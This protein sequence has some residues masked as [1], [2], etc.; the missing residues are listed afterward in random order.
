MSGCSPTYYILGT[1]L[2]AW[3]L[4]SLSTKTQAREARAYTHSSFL[5]TAADSVIDGCRMVWQPPGELQD[6]A[7]VQAWLVVTLRER[8]RVLED[9]LT[10][11]EVPLVT[12][13]TIAASLIVNTGVVGAPVI[14]PIRWQKQVARAKNNGGKG[15]PGGSS[16]P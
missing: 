12:S 8:E 4:S 7:W 15:R 6:G 13:T 11:S 5:R 1:E 2:N 10:G 9:W 16:F 3:C 14:H